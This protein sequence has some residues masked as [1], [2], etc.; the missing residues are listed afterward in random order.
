MHR[1]I[2]TQLQISESFFSVLRSVGHED[3][4]KRYSYGNCLDSCDK[5]ECDANILRSLNYPF[6]YRNWLVESSNDV[7]ISITSRK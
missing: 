7:R 1:C 6:C 2:V 5:M 3:W 4:K